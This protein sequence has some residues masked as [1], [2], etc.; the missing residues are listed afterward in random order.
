VKFSIISPSEYLA[1]NQL[2]GE[3]NGVI[4]GQPSGISVVLRAPHSLY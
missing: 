2:N 3:D 4:I 1:P